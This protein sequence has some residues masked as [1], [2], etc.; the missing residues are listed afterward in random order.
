MAK[1][2][3][4]QTEVGQ[5][6][7]LDT[8]ANLVGILIILVVV[9]GAK[10]KTSVENLLSDQAESVEA[11]ELNQSVDQLM[12]VN[13]AIE[14]QYADAQRIEFEIAY[15]QQERD[16]L[17]T[18]LSRLQ[19]EY[20]EAV[21][22]FDSETQ[23]AIE[24]DDEKRELEEKLADIE[25]QLENIGEEESAP[26]LLQHLPTPMAKTVFNR[27]LH[28]ML[29][30]NRV[31]V[32]PWDE[33]VHRLKQEASLAVQ[34]TSKDSISGQL[35]P[36][37]GFRMDYRFVSKR[38]MVSDGTRA[39]MG[40]VIELDRFELEPTSTVVAES[41]SESLAQGQLHIALAGRNPKDT[42]ITVWVYPDSFDEF[43]TLKTQLF[44]QGF[45]TAARPLPNN[46][47]I[48]A[49]PNGSRSVAQ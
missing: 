21:A 31:S 3:A 47:R 38:G 49:S 17:L 9:I 44:E 7:F 33:L 10:A 1:K 4:D 36:I 48:G 22:E 46:I 41:V 20:E 35:G 24:H 34:R 43:R 37:D 14:K 39:G 5:D 11:T 2:Q 40:Q 16:G 30:N 12:A 18:E 27:E 29:K 42:V 32:V 6:S 8:I 26:S 19:I 28:L 25:S 45:L 15:R 23:S 13:Q